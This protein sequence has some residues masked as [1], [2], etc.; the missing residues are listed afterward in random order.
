MNIARLVIFI[1]GN[2]SNLQAVIDAIEQG[3][4]HAKI[5]SVI[6]NKR[7]AFG[8]QRAEKAQLPVHVLLRTAYASRDAYDAALAELTL[9]LKPD[10]IILAGWMHVFN[11]MFLQY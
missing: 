8:I 1:S 10:W 6:A 2:G 9:G 5:V 3:V 11:Q 4:L 7:D